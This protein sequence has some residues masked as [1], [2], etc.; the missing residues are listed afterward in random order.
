MAMPMGAAPAAA[1]PETPVAE[2]TPT[3]GAPILD[4]LAATGWKE[5][6]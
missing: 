6:R 1:E 3:A 2:P 4:A 5:A